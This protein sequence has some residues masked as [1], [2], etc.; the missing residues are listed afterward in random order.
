MTSLSARTHCATLLIVGSLYNAG[1]L[2]EIK[3]EEKKN[4]INQIWVGVALEMGHVSKQ[5]DGF[6][7]PAEWGLNLQKQDTCHQRWLCQ[8]SLG[9]A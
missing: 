5:G 9:Q 8:E 3:E 6:P 2:Y 4:G 1:N 7:R